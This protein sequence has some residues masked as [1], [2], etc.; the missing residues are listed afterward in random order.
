VPFTAVNEDT[1]FEKSYP[2]LEGWFVWD[3]AA[4]KGTHWDNLKSTIVSEDDFDI[5][6][7]AI[8][9]PVEVDSLWQDAYSEFKAGA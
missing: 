1:I 9:L 7:R 2:G 4:P 6:K 5:G 3:Y 8:G